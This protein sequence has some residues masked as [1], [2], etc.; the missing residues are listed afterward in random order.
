VK[1]GKSGSVAVGGCRPPTTIKVW[2]PFVRVFHW[3][4]VALFLAAFITGDDFEDAHIVVGYVVAGLIAA[5]VVWGFIGSHHARFS[6]FVRPPQ[7][8]LAYLRD[9]LRLKA[10]RH[11][12]HN[13]AAAA[14][15]VAL[16]VMSATTCITG[17]LITTDAL[18]GAEW[19]EEI[20]EVLAYLTIGF[21]A[22]HVFGVLLA[23]FLHRENLVLSMFTGKKRLAKH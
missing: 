16:L 2:D 10:P 20:H 6:H 3:S 23:S 4:L 14:M 7:E 5:R 9:E 18:W 11:I 19:V 21:V 15:I 17:Y 13:P 8:T 22:V 12:G 1:S